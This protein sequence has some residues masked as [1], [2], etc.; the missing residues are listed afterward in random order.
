[1]H[2]FILICVKHALDESDRDPQDMYY[3]LHSISRTFTLRFANIDDKIFIWSPATRLYSILF[4]MGS[5]QMCVQQM[6]NIKLV[7]VN[8]RYSRII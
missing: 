8:A 6:Q 5:R 1:M 2:T 4:T 7:F 3:L